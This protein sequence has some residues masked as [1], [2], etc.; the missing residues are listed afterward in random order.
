MNGLLLAL[1]ALLACIAFALAALVGWLGGSVD[2]EHGFEPPGDHEWTAD[3]HG[4]Y[5][6][7]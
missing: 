6:R 1:G 2:A 7:A 5:D 4:G 3:D